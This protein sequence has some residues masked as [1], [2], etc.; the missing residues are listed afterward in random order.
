MTS[1]SYWLHAALS[2]RMKQCG[3]SVSR[4]VTALSTF[5]RSSLYT[6]TRGDVR[7]KRSHLKI[8]SQGGT[9]DAR[10]DSILR[11]RVDSERRESPGRFDP[12]ASGVLPKKI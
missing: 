6:A 10:P 12:K 7:P 9:T 5:S 2:S 1:K 8:E 4:S 11:H 3:S